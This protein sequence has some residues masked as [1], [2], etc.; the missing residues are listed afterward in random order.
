MK[1]IVAAAVLAIASV[2]TAQAAVFDFSYTTINGIN[3]QG[4]VTATDYLGF[5]NFSVDNVTGFRNG[6]AITGYDFFDPTLQSF[7][8]LNGQA[9]D[10]DFSY[11]VG[12]DNYEI[13]FPG[14]GSGNV[15]YEYLPDSTGLYTSLTV[16]KFSLTPAA[17]DA[18]P[19]P[20]TW[21]LMLVGF[22]GVGFAM[23]HRRKVA[24]RVSYAV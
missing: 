7:T 6:A 17:A 21:A 16:T 3:A 2:S 11:Y 18:V 13:T 20:A 23:R 19:E 4:K 10:V 5:G 1:K 15:G 8:F 14:G 22:G 9:S 24:V 12:A